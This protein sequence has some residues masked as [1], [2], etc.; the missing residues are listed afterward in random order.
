[1]TLGLVQPGTVRNPVPLVTINGSTFAGIESAEITTTNTFQA[2]TW[3]VEASV[4]KN[5]NYNLAW[6]DKQTQVQVKIFIGYGTAQPTRLLTGNVD[7]YSFSLEKNRITISGR[8]MTALLIDTKT[9]DSYTNQTASEI[10]TIIAQKHGLTPAVTATSTPVGTYYASNHT[11]TASGSLSRATTE[12]DMLVYLAQQVGFDVFVDDM[13]LYF[14][15]PAT[16]ST[17]PYLVPWSVGPDGVPNAPI[18]NLTLEHNLMMAPGVSV[19]I[20]SWNSQT[21][22]RVAAT[23][24]TP[25]YGGSASGNTQDYVYPVPNLTPA[26]AQTAA[27]QRLN[28]ITRHL[29]TITYDAPGD[30]IL[31]PR[32]LIQLVGTDSRFDTL[33]FPDRIQRKIS[34]KGGFTMNVTAKNIPPSMQQAAV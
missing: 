11:H 1:M 9:A 33:Y 31:M 2:S 13:T 22:Q 21:N 24:K 15:P 26:A 16:A 28:D 7:F 10:A 4:S 30:T 23:A 14:Q 5:P 3:Q 8:D 20:I 34:Q 17:P 32:S 6:W 27:N 19:T 29:R 25:G 18:E 12:W